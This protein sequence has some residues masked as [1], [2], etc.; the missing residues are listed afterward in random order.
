MSTELGKSFLIRLQVRIYRTWGTRQILS[1][2][3][4]LHKMK[5]F[6]RNTSIFPT[7]SVL[8]LVWHTVLKTANLYLPGKSP[9]VRFCFVTAALRLIGSRSEL[10]VSRVSTSWSWVEYFMALLEKWS[11][12][13]ICHLVFFFLSSFYFIIVLDLKK[14]SKTV[15]KVTIYPTPRFL[16]E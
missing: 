7:S 14:V 9:Q 6:G 2:P 3:Q 12:S 8:L 15:L 11:N 4:F 5:W 16:E 10:G 1:G 13:N